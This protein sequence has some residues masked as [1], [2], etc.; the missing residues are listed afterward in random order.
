MDQLFV[1]TFLWKINRIN[2]LTVLI[3]NKYYIKFIHNFKKNIKML[4]NKLCL[5]ITFAKMNILI[6]KLVRQKNLTFKN[7]F[8][9]FSHKFKLS[10]VVK[11]IFLY[12]VMFKMC[13]K[14][15]MESGPVLYLSEFKWSC[16]EL[17]YPMLGNVNRKFR[18]YYKY[19]EVCN[20]LNY[21]Y[22]Q[23]DTDKSFACT[24]NVHSYIIVYV[25]VLTK[26]TWL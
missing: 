24:F 6:S 19:F 17:P 11:N 2:I 23:T 1:Q 16:Q 26:S 8:F 12:D 3:Q 7:I 10:C 21:S 14:V 18:V 22:R 15:S 5:K 13:R 4:R 20:I 25:H 9:I